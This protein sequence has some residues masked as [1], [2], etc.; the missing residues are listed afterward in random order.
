MELI[1]TNEITILFKIFLFIAQGCRLLTG[2]VKLKV[3]SLFAT[4][5]F[6]LTKQVFLIPLC[7]KTVKKTGYSLYGKDLRKCTEKGILN[8]MIR[9]IFTILNKVHWVTVTSFQVFLHLLK[10]HVE[11]GNYFVKIKS[12]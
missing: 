2:K 5:I 8:Y 9:L 12:T 10:N 11:L 3:V 1:L 4:L 7:Q 6:L